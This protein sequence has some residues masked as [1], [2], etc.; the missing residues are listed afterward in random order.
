V[1][2]CVWVDALH[3]NAGRICKMVDSASRGGFLSAFGFVKSVCQCSPQVEMGGQRVS[4]GGTDC[5]D[6]QR[7]NAR[8][9]RIIVF[10]SLGTCNAPFTSYCS[11]TSYFYSSPKHLQSRDK[12][13]T[14]TILDLSGL[15][16]FD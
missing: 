12:N 5:P 8:M 14:R 13:P 6:R 10:F 2:E 3:G 15:S 11:S 4:C 9:S 16:S 7:V 1:V